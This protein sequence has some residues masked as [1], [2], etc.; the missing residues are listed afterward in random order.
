MRC[1]FKLADKKA[2]RI[3]CPYCGFTTTCPE[4]GGVETIFRRCPVLSQLKPDEPVPEPPPMPPLSERLANWAIAQKEHIAAGSPKCTEEQMAARLAICEACDKFD[5][6]F[7]RVCGCGCSKAESTWF[8]KLYHANARCPL[9][10]PKWVAVV[11]GE[12]GVQ[13]AT[14]KAGAC[15]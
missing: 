11:A 14:K 2:K 5:G 10:P 15:G 9:D 7:C 8:N 3:L 4:C 12:L 13:E 6:R 1:K